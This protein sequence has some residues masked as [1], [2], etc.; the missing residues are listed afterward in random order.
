MSKH[1]LTMKW[2]ISKKKKCVDT[3]VVECGAQQELHIL[4]STQ[5]VSFCA[6]IGCNMFMLHKYLINLIRCILLS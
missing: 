1:D 4:T 6:D 5:H 3:N 2:Q